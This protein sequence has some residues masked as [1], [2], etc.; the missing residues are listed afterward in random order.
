MIKVCVV[1]ISCAA[2]R[3]LKA[4]RVAQS[5]ADVRV[6]KAPVG[7]AALLHHGSAPVSD[8]A[9]HTSTARTYLVP[10]A[11]TMPT[12]STASV[13]SVLQGIANV[14]EKKSLINEKMVLEKVRKF[15]LLDVFTVL[16]VLLC[17][18]ISAS[19]H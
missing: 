19:K 1:V 5:P 6:A 16:K 10:E 15:Y 3:N 17:W 7:L 9:V 13:G 2:G 18:L 4:R 8:D 12:S 11:I 14:E